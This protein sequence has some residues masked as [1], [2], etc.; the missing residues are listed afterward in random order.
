[1]YPTYT[2]PLLALFLILGW[3][4]S[5]T[6][7]RRFGW[8]RAWPVLA[9]NTGLFLSC[10]DPAAYF[11]SRPLESR[12]PRL[13]LRDPEPRQAGA[14]VVL[15]AN[16]EPARSHFPIAIPD[17][18]T[19]SRCRYAAW[20]HANWKPL[21]VYVSGG[22]RS[23]GQ[24]PFSAAMAHVVESEGVSAGNIVQEARSVNTWENAS[25][26]A[27]LLGTKRIRHIVLVLDAD[28]MLRADLCFRKLG[29]QVSPAAIDHHSVT[30]TMR[31]L[32]PS[33]RAL[34]LNEI[35]LHEYV[36]LAWYWSQQRI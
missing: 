3:I 13:S 32:I 8:R 6:I 20:L 18:D 25:F 10:W 24:E 30:M 12:Y 4:G 23:P 28:S 34:R 11:F 31:D 1:M 17:K 19:Y 29:I 33:W 21:P 36:G 9:A 7:C 5:I 26:T 27:E 22:N 2:E 15:A 16:V 35:A 14:I